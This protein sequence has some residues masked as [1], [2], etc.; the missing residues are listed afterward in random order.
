MSFFA[1]LTLCFHL[2]ADRD[3]HEVQELVEK[4]RYKKTFR[5]LFYSKSDNDELQRLGKQVDETLLL[6]QIG[7]TLS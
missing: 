1:F 4:Y 5:R 2:N 6:F 3:L 7:R